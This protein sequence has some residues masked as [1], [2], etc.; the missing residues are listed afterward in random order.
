MPSLTDLVKKGKIE[1][2]SKGSRLDTGSACS[3]ETNWD[4]VTH[5]LLQSSSYLT[6]KGRGLE[7]HLSDMQ[8][9]WPFTDFLVKLR[10]NDYDIKIHVE[11]DIEKL[12]K[13]YSRYSSWSYAKELPELSCFDNLWNLAL[14]CSIYYPWE[15]PFSATRFKAEVAFHAT[16]FM[17]GTKQ[18]LERYRTFDRYNPACLQKI[19]ENL[20]E[21]LN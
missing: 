4:L 12:D 13:K 18:Q 11:A 5:L 10:Y 9:L 16:M 19:E 1:F 17:I 6:I 7:E 21:F 3:E 8:N 2:Y 15:Q 20:E 14:C